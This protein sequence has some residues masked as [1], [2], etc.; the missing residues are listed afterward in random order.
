MK[1]TFDTEAEIEFELFKFLREKPQPFPVAL[2]V[3]RHRNVA[4][5]EGAQDVMGGALNL[6]NGRQ[7][8]KIENNGQHHR[9][10][11]WRRLTNQNSCSRCEG[12]KRAS[13]AICLPREPNREKVRSRHLVSSRNESLSESQI[14]AP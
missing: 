12:S 2:A 9:G 5:P 4:R 14:H 13:V 11:V 7:C 3:D 10:R 6:T 8:P 1:I